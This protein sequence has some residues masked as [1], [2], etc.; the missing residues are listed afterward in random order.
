[1]PVETRRRTR[2]SRVRTG[3]K[4]AQPYR[5]RS[6]RRCGFGADGRTHGPSTVNGFEE[7]VRRALQSKPNRPCASQIGTMERYL[8]QIVATRPDVPIV[9]I[10]D[11]Q[12]PS[13]DLFWDSRSNDRHDT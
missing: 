4:T 7:A 2:D 13:N 5:L 10:G 11:E 12:H 3:R 1:M 6:S 9:Q 8:L